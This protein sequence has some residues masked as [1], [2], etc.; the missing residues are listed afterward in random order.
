MVKN[1][2]ALITVEEGAKGGFGAHVLHWLAESGELDRGLKIR[3]LTLKDAFIDQ[4]NPSD[5]YTEAGLDIRAIRD[6]IMEV[7][8]LIKNDRSTIKIVS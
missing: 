4:A 8:G 7:F 2:D 1:H 3:T 6:C 5:M